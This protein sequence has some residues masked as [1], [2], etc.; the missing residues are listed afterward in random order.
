MIF[1]FGNN[2]VLVANCK[3]Y[4]MGDTEKTTIDFQFN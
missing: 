2:N 3:V 4:A 1:A